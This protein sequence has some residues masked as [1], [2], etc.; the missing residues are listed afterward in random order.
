MHTFGTLDREKC[1]TLTAGLNK[2]RIVQDRIELG[3]EVS[4]GQAGPQFSAT[5]FCSPT[6]FPEVSGRIVLRR[7]RNQIAIVIRRITTWR[8]CF[9]PT[10]WGLRRATRC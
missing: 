2:L 6:T 5:C 7:A 9:E 10:H 4:S 8:V 3:L 1:H